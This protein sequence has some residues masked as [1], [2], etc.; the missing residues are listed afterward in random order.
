MGYW[1]F[2]LLNWLQ[3]N[4]RTPLGDAVMVGV[5]HLGDKGVVWLALAAVLLWR[6]HTRRQGAAVALA[7]LFS[8]LA[9]NLTL[10]PLVA[11]P[12]PFAFASAVQLLIAP[13]DDFSFPSGHTAA[14]FAAVGALYATRWPGRHAAAVLAGCIAFSRLYLYVHF[15]TDVLGGALLGL[16]LGGLGA[17]AAGGLSRALRRV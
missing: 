3:T 11:R 12:R 8:L 7:L 6:A 15:P 9:C 14:S 5:T 16:V 13:P 4:A 1:E 10:K 17:L 2:D